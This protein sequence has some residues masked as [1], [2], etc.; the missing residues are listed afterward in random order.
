[1]R[2]IL[3]RL[4]ATALW[5]SAFCLATIALLVGL[6]LGGRMLDGTL[7]LLH[8]PRTDFQI[9]SLAEICGYMLAAASFL[10]LAP[11]LKAGAHIRVTMALNGLSVGLRHIAEFFAFSIAAV[12]AAYMTWHFANFAYVSFLFDEVSAGVIRVQLGYP[13][14]FVAL[15]SLI[16]TIALIDELVAIATRGRPSFRDAEEAFTMTKEG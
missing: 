12:A 16:L 14:A 3:D 13:Q 2:L 6:Q 10:A 15:G 1:M 8:L 7:S 5:A 4:Y 9:L 11:T